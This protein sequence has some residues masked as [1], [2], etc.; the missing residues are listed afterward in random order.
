MIQVHQ[1]TFNPFMENTYVLADQTRE[2]V[3]IDPGCYEK[4]E[5]NEL[6]DFIEAH[7]LDVKLLLNTHG[8]IDHVLGNA[9]VKKHYK[10]PLWIGE[11]DLP[12]LKSVEVYAANYGFQQYQPCEPDRLLNEG[13]TVSFGNSQLEIVFVPG[14]APGHIAFYHAEQQFC[15]GGD[16]LFQEGIGRTDL[17]GGDM[18]TLI[19]SIHTKFFAW[20]DKVV[21][22]PGH[23]PDTTVGHEKRHNP[24]CAIN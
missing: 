24:F 16:V 21:V 2:A 19:K 17:P 20:P 5:Q 6:A 10:V 23:G 14:H 15:I 8:H 13:D 22:Y 4:K 9:F 7:G 1:F 3:I 11:K 18:E 12:T